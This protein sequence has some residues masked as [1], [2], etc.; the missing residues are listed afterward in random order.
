MVESLKKNLEK[1]QMYTITNLWNHYEVL[2]CYIL[3]AQLQ[4]PFVLILQ[5]SRTL[6]EGWKT[7]LTEDFPSFGALMMVLESPNI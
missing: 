6:L 2:A 4:S 7:I 1:N 5:V 3:S